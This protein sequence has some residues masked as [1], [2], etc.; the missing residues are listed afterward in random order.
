MR[1]LND[2]LQLT[3]PMYNYCHQVLLHITILPLHCHKWHLQCCTFAFFVRPSGWFTICHNAHTHWVTS[4]Q[5]TILVP[6]HATCSNQ[7]E[8]TRTKV[9]AHCD[10]LYNY[11]WALARAREARA[12]ARVTARA[13]KVRAR[14]TA[15][16][17][18]VT[19]RAA[20]VRARDM[21]YSN[22]SVQ[23]WWYH[24]R[25]RSTED[26]PCLQHPTK[27]QCFPSMQ[28]AGRGAP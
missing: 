15:R 14:V 24:S 21:A 17:A 6:V 26:Q 5:W 18:R 4:W 13:A 9:H 7:L 28:N 27:Q 11:L 22:I 25:W 20:R 8:P 10:I 3:I 12:W 16:A 1:R 2:C 19:A 23:H